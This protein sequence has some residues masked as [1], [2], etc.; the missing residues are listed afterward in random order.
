MLS[1]ESLQIRRN[2]NWLKSLSFF[3]SPALR[4]DSI[5]VVTRW[6]WPT[7]S[8][9]VEEVTGDQLQAIKERLKTCAYRKD[10]QAKAGYVVGEV[11]GA[12]SSKEAMEGHD[13]QRTRTTTEARWTHSFDVAGNESPGVLAHQCRPIL[14]RDPSHVDGSIPR[15]QAYV[16]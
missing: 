1:L 9:F 12:G 5:G 4:S 8:S 2:H 13:R 16:G 6:Q 10:A 7:Q 11:L 3:F 15:R 14:G